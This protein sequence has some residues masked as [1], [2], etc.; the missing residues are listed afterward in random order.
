MFAFHMALFEAIWK[1][2]YVF[3]VLCGTFC[4]L[5]LLAYSRQRWILSFV[6]FWLAYKAKEVAVMLPLVLVCYEYW[7]GK[8]RWLRLAPFFL[9][10]LSFGIQGILLNPNQDNDYTFRFTPAALAKTSVFYADRLFLVP[11]LGFLLPAAAYVSR[12]RRTWFGGRPTG[13]L[14]K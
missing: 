2:M 3:D 11:Y 9:V 1:P 4:V 5:S 8:R 13:R 14:S 10:S 6:A 7:F 12:N